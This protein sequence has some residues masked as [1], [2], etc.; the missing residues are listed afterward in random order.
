MKYKELISMIEGD[1]LTIR[2]GISRLADDMRKYLSEIGND[3]KIVDEID[4]A[5]KVSRELYR[6]QPDGTTLSHLALNRAVDA[7]ILKQ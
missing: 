3:F 5:K 7:I 6:P 4:F 1:E 2:I